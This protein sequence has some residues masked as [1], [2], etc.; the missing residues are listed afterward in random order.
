M[1]KAFIIIFL[2]LFSI[3]T[4]ASELKL[5][6]SS[7][8]SRINPIL[9]TDSA[10]SE[11]AGWIFNGLFKY[12]KDGNVIGDLAKE[13][14][15]ENNT[16]LIIK[17]KQN[18]Q[19]HDGENFSA[20]DVLF[21][22]DTLM[23]PKI[24]TPYKTTFKQV[25]SVEKL[26][27]FTIKTV[28]ITPYYKA[29]HVWM[30]GILPKH[31]LKNDKDLMT[32]EFNKNPIGTGN[33]KLK[34]FKPNQDIV[35]EVNSNYFDKVPQIKTIQYK[36]V[37][38]PNIEFNMLKLRKIDLGGLTPLQIDRQLEDS[39]KN[40]YNIYEQA[41]RSYTYMGFNLK[42][43]TFENPK[44]REAINLSI[45]KQELIDI[46][47]FSHGAITNG[48]FLPG[49]F[50]FNPNIKS[51]YNP[52]KA[53]EILTELGFNDTN[54]L[55]FTVTTNAGNDTRIN[56][57]QILQYQLKKVGIDMKIKVMEWQAFLNTVVL[58]KKFEAVLLGWSMSLMP[59]ARSIWH[60]SSFKKGGF[61]FIGYENK[62]VD[63]NIEIAER[64]TDTKK[65][66]KLYQ[67]IYKEIAH[68][69]PYIFLYIPNSIT[70]VNN[71]I[72]NVS[73]SLIGVM[74]NQHEWIK[75]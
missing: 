52:K 35:L 32:S 42:N 25:Q 37:P 49:T 15:F 47:F 44:I 75:E 23:S 72:K 74:H 45:D 30:T 28:Y 1:K 67:E 5:T 22:Y 69:N 8:P 26:D 50:A 10:S 19:W 14:Y 36:F 12:D 65:L 2:I 66:T 31:I 61:N 3:F 11:I 27:D 41:S 7:N 64:T 21:T 16:T 54:K 39:F 58:P 68:D 40:N 59:D 70:A 6:I 29:L 33:Y 51:H 56:A 17:L 71:K 63:E 53:K 73:S 57:A 38:D 18:V 9:A 55:S 24:F 46:L 60:S 62:K 43:K 48:P 4:F 20:D 13:W 34:S